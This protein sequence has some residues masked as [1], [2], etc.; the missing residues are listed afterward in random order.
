MSCSKKI[1]HKNYIPFKYNG[2]LN[3][4]VLVADKYIGN[5]VF[6]TGFNRTVLDSSFCKQNGL[7]TSSGMVINFRQEMKGS[8]DIITQDLSLLQRLFYQFN[9]ALSRQQ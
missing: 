6:D 3:L 1:V 7:K 2:H 5:F 9:Q 8:G 4:N